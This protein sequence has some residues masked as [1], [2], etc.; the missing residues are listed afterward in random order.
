MVLVQLRQ[1]ARLTELLH[2]ETDVTQGDSVCGCP[3]SGVI[4][5]A[6]WGNSRSSVFGSPSAS[7]DRA[8]NER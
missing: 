5:G 6:S 1:V 3:S 4:T 7:P 8:W 2:T